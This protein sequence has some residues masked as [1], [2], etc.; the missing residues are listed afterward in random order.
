MKRF[1]EEGQMSR[2]REEKTANAETR[3][4]AFQI[5]TALRVSLPLFHICT[6]VG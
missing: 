4:T 1:P 5:S 3:E 6:S 2:L